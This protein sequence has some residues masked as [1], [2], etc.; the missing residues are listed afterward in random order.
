VEISAKS[1]PPVETAS[2]SSSS[3]KEALARKEVFQ[4][5]MR[6]VALAPMKKPSPPSSSLRTFTAIIVRC[7]QDLGISIGIYV[8][9]VDILVP[10]MRN[11]VLLPA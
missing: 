7:G 3:A 10:F 9:H 5:P 4:S 1:S 8:H 11:K 2:V 6:W